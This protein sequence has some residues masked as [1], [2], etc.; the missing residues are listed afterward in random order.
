MN[1]TKLA[2]LSRKSLV[3]GL[4]VAALSFILTRPAHAYFDGGTISILLQ[5]LLGGVAVAI[6]SISLFWQKFR[7]FLLG[8]KSEKD[9]KEL[10]HEQENVKDRTNKQELN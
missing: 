5:G 6:A 8:N 4:Y 9:E 3:A 1:Q 2:L 7:N 10:T